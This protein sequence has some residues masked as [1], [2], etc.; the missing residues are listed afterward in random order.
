MLGGNSMGAMKLPSSLKQFKAGGGKTISNIEVIRIL[1]H[2]F[3]GRYVE[4]MQSC[5]P[6]CMNCTRERRDQE[7]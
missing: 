7:A 3:G 6:S 1:K 5:M 4:P 2:F